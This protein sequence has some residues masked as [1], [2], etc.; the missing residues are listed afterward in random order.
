MAAWALSSDA[1]EE[2]PYVARNSVKMPSSFRSVQKNGSVTEDGADLQ[3]KEFRLDELQAALRI[4]PLGPEHDYF[5]GMLAN[6]TNHISQ[7]I[8]LL[9]SVLPALRTSRSDRAAIALQALADD[10]NKKFQYG[11]AARVYDDLLGH[12]SNQLKPEQLQGTKDD[13][14]VMRILREAPAQTITWNGDV[15]LKTERNP[16]NSMNLVLTVNGVRGPWLL[17]TGANIS[18]VSNSF[19]ERLGLRF[20]PGIAEAQAGITGV[21][22]PLH[23]AL[24]STL[25]IGGATLHN[26]VVMVLEDAN[27]NISL[28]KSAYQIHG[29]IGYPVFQALGA[30]RFAQDGEFE[31][32][33]KARATGTGARMYMDHLSPIIECKV[34]GSSLPFNF[35]TGA[36]ETELFV[37]YYQ[38]FRSESGT[39][40]RGKTKTAG[41]GGVVKQKIYVQPQL[42][43]DIGDKIVILKRV[44]I[45]TSRTGS[46]NEF[47]YGNL[48]QDIVVNF[49]SFTLDFSAMKFTLGAPRS[50][51]KDLKQ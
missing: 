33:D 12:F 24:L 30:I 29:I 49:E 4:M 43:L 20:L 14:G 47:L 22:N 41:A 16:M 36:S 34:E 2:N 37:R 48:G 44:A 45:Q 13:M 18:V 42:N 5:A 7:S 17:D 10:Y 50:P 40:K 25:E 1:R 23:V 26:V 8:Q 9:N 3:L 15:R 27:L 38:R 11:D 35:D 46:E 32:G 28:G 6:R 51:T 21:E 19:A 39:W 31:A